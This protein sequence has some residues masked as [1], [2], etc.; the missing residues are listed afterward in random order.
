MDEFWGVRALIERSYHRA[1]NTVGRVTLPMGDDSGNVQTHQIEGY[2]GE[3]RDGMQHY[4]T[5]GFASMPLRGAKGVAN[6]QSGHRGFATIVATEDPRYRVKN[7]QPGELTTYMVDGAK[8]DGTGGTTRSI[9]KGALG[10]VTSLF[11]K[12]INMGTDADTVT[13]SVK[14]ATININ[15]KSGGTINITGDNGDVIVH[16]VSLRNHVHTDVTAGSDHTGKP[17]G[18]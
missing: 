2:K 11:G 4:Q 18:S 1:H 16:G 12:T 6:Y 14:G 9:L 7:Q 10:W 15:A 3:L 5:F 17:V 13:I 8:T